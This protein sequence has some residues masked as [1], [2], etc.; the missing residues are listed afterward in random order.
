[1]SSPRGRL[2]LVP[3]PLDFGVAGREAPADQSEVKPLGDFRSGARLT[4]RVAENAK[5]A[6]AC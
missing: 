2:L 6:R 1:V 3:T 4:Q 5:T